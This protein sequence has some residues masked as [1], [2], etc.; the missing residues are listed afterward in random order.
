MINPIKRTFL[1]PA[2]IALRKQ[3]MTSSNTPLTQ[4]AISLEADDFAVCETREFGAES[5]LLAWD[6]LTAEEQEL[7]LTRGAPLSSS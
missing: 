3:N 1:V 6:A 4:H 7:A 5:G 2:D